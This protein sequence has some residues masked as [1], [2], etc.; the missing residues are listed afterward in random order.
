MCNFFVKISSAF[1]LVA[2]IVFNFF[3][4]LFG[5]GDI[6]PTDPETPET[7]VTEYTTLPEVI[8]TKPV[9]VPSTEENTTV[10]AETTYTTVAPTTNAPFPTAPKPTT[11]P[12]T[13]GTTTPKT[14]KPQTT[15]EF[16]PKVDEA[17]IESFTDFGGTGTDTFTSARAVSKGGFVAC[18]ISNSKNGEFANVASDWGNT[19][20]YVAMFDKDAKTVWVKA[21]GSEE[22]NVRIED[23]AALSDGSV[24][25]VGY[26]TVT[27]IG[28]IP[29]CRGSI[30]SFV[31]KYSADGTLQWIKCYGGNR[32]DMLLS[33]APLDNGFVAGGKTDSTDK[34]FADS[35]EHSEAKA[36]LMRF[37]A[38]GNIVW[39]RYLAGNYGATVDCID[40]DSNGN[41]FFTS[42][43]AASTGD[44]EIE[45]MGK[46]YLDT[47]VFKYN[48]DGERLWSAA[49]AS[50]GRDNFRAIA[51]DGEGGCVVA[52]NYE[53]VTTYLPD[54][55]F[56]S[57]HNCGGIDA[58]VIRFN[59]NGTKRWMRSVAGF[60]DDFIN[61][62]VK[63]ANGGFAVAG[64]TTSS[65]RDFASVGNKGQNDAFAALITP[66]GNLADV[67]GLG[68]ARKDAST[69]VVYTTN[70]KLV[71]LGQT[72]SSNGDFEGM[73]TH[74]TDEIVE[75]F[76]QMGDMYSGFVA[77]YGVTILR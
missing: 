51:A 54:G 63:T 50:S 76:G 42:V 11:V 67:K 24:V 28:Y 12:S 16:G 21:L 39:K 61:D 60:S 32:T 40:T 66:A 27:D 31:A 18:G 38:D 72:T 73:N 10:K 74:L 22:G 6:I 7:T 52:G 20:G 25:A 9:T 26:T 23:V 34:T 58:V 19:Y 29:A 77:K 1:V 41:I 64:Y 8:T 44:F 75:N 71:V 37:D 47:A 14:T 13:A 17:K 15:V 70:G 46:G 59:A 30:D 33:V 65:N 3:G 62:I 2:A 36:V 49:V 53:M 69:S 55:T 4:N 35:G 68:G 45:G 48:S 57:L 5:V 56:A 43:T